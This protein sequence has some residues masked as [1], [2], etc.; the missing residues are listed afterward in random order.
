MWPGV[1]NYS[2]QSLI[3]NI[4]PTIHTQH[5]IVVCIDV[6]TVHSIQPGAVLLNV[7]GPFGTL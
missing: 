5:K 3:A 1:M 2:D 7:F 4:N 6:S